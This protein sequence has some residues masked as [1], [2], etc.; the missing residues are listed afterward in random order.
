VLGQ[1]TVI[2]A[3]WLADTRPELTSLRLLRRCHVEAF[4]IFDAGRASR[5]RVHRG[6]AISVRHH[7]RAVHDL[8]LFLD[9]LAAWG[10]AE[11]PTGLLLHRSDLPRLPQPL[12]RALARTSTPP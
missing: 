11:R 1:T 9:D 4:L 5:G 10:W 3:G 8:R 6:R 12:P 7:H 2:F